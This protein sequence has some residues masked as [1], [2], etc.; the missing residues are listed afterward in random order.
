M[1]RLAQIALILAVALSVS[2]EVS[3]QM[4]V[5]I[6]DITTLGGEHV[7]KLTGFGLVIGLA[8]TGGTSPTTKQFA[9]N[10]LQKLG[11][12]ADPIMRENIQRSQE[13]TNNMSVVMVQAQLMPHMKEGQRIDVSVS[14]FDNAI[15]LAGGSLIMTE[16][17]GPDGEIYALASG[18][19]SLNGGDFGGNAAK[20]VKNHP[21]SGRIPNGATIEKEVPSTIVEQDC[22][23]LLLSQPEFATAERISEAI[24]VYSPGAAAVH[25]A[26]CVIVRLPSNAIAAPYRFIAECRELKVEPETVARVIINERTGTIVF[27]EKVKVSRAAITHGNLVVSTVETPEVSQPNPFSNGETTTVPRTSVDVDEQ[28]AAISVVEDTT[29]VAELA[30]SL[31]A[32]GVSPRDLSSIFQALKEAGALHAE[33]EIK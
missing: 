5:R 25:D 31:N 18:P 28:G 22:F 13:K 9:L 27:G 16:L 33:L 20:V 10:V 14:A 32:L 1:T 8:N 29:T 7:N 11:N 4:Q 23:R 17:T 12:R 30:A 15:S 24:N 3:A 21:T 6:R 2:S 26:A 19:V